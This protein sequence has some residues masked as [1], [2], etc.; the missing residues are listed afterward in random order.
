VKQNETNTKNSWGSD[1]EKMKKDKQIECINCDGTGNVRAWFGDCDVTECVVYKG[2]G[3]VD[4]ATAFAEPPW[5]TL[6]EKRGLR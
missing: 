6:D 2:E 5:D 4:E 1:G 3:F